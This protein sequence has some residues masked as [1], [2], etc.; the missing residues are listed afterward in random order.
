MNDQ[1]YVYHIHKK[2]DF[3]LQ[4][5]KINEV[6]LKILQFIENYLFLC[7]INFCCSN[8]QIFYANVISFNLREKC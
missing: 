7:S 2:F 5:S 6:K 4:K 3:E 1:F 8:L